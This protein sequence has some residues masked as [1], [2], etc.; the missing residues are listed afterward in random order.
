MTLP[1]RHG[2]GASVGVT[3]LVIASRGFDPTDQYVWYT[4]W[5]GSWKAAAGKAC[6]M[7]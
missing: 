7:A 4:S 6:G 5:M 3:L 2:G 1:H